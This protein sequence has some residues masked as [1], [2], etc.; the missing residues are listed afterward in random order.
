MTGIEWTDRTWNPTVGCSRVSP[1]CDQSSGEPS[2]SVAPNVVPRDESTGPT[3]AI[4]KRERCAAPALACDIGIGFARTAQVVA[5]SMFS[6]VLPLRDNVQV[7]SPVVSLDPVPVVHDLSATER[8]AEDLSCDESVLVDISA[9]VS[10]GMAR[11]LHENIA[12]RCN[13]PAPFPGRVL[14]SSQLALI[15]HPL[16]VANRWELA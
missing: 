11:P 16:S 3:G 12:I 15:C 4:E 13:G 5:P 9:L 10:H 1:G 14:W 7:G 2:C 6:S 8:P